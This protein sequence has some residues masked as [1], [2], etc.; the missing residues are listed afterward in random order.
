MCLERLG[1]SLLIIPSRRTSSAE[2]SL[3]PSRNP[4]SAS[5]SARGTP[6]WAKEIDSVGDTPLRSASRGTPQRIGDRRSRP[7]KLDAHVVQG[8]RARELLTPDHLHRFAAVPPVERHSKRADRP[9][10]DGRRCFEQATRGAAVQEVET[11]LLA[12]HAEV[13]VGCGL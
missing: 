5:S 3:P 12:E 13:I 2:I 1:S 7:E 9:H 10:V 11:K 4:D 8:S 6:Q